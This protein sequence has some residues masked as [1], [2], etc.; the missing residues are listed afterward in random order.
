MPR[1]ASVF[2]AASLDGYIAT[3]EDSLTWLTDTPG[4][5]DNGYLA[6]LSRVDTLLIGRRTYDWILE[7]EGPEHFPYTTQRCI[8]FTHRPYEALFPNVTFTDE[9]PAKVLTRLKAENGAGV[10]IVG[11]GKLIRELMG[12]GLID[13]WILTFAPVLLGSGIPLFYPAR[14]TRLHLVE[15]QRFGQFVQL[16]YGMES[17]K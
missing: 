14:E 8:V 5:E 10:W 16:R 13:E 6:F 11:G 1:K 15:V 2:I 3:K 9:P 12:E 7:H 4:E 17:D